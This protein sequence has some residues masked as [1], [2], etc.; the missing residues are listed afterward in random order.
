M[1]IF[2]WLFFL[3]LLYL[4]L[5]P[6]TVNAQ[7]ANLQNGFSLNQ[8]VSERAFKT[9][10]TDS[11]QN[12]FTIKTNP[13]LIFTERFQVQFDIPVFKTGFAIYSMEVHGLNR[14]QTDVSNIES[15]LY[16]VRIIT[17]DNSVF[18]KSFVKTN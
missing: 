18:V 9:N 13:L 8:P 10:T 2:P 3:I 7:T 4:S 14:V 12:S 11:A 6:I 5:S 17:A 1:K 15:G 16:Q